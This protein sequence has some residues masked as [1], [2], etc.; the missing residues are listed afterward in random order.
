MKH[1]LIMLFLTSTLS[2]S[3]QVINQ[4]QVYIEATTLSERY[5]MDDNQKLQ[6]Q[7]IIE[8]KYVDLNN[9]MGYR[10]QSP[11]VY[12]AK[13]KAIYAGMEQSIQ[14]VMTKKQLAVYQ[15][16]QEDSKMKRGKNVSKLRSTKVSEQERP[17]G[18]KVLPPDGKN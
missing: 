11:K 1:I 4:K 15:M 17:H 16:R 13:R 10:E 7:K 3:A 2:M 5:G 12:R 14:Q 18:N 6:L 9:I 8:K